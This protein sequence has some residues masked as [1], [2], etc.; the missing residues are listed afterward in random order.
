MARTCRGPHFQ[1]TPFRSG[2]GKFQ[3]RAI[4]RAV[5][6]Q[7]SPPTGQADCHWARLGYPH[8][9]GSF[10][11]TGGRASIAERGVA[12]GGVPPQLVRRFV[13]TPSSGAPQKIPKSPAARAQTT[14]GRERQRAKKCIPLKRKAAPLCANLRWMGHNWGQRC[15]KPGGS[16]AIGAISKKI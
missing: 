7:K 9:K 8:F 15:A 12:W 13:G 14:N 1:A 16:G 10:L 5:T 3:P 4:I 11:L 2:W 6:I